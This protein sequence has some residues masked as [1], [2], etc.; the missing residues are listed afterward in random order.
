MSSG[1]T[2]SGFNDI[3]FNVVLNAMMTQAS[4]PLTALQDRQSALKS[5]LTSFETLR[6]R[7]DTLRSAADGLKTMDA[8]ST[9][10]GTSSNAA[11]VSISSGPS[12]TPAHYDVVVTSLARAQVTASAETFA[13]ADTTVVASG[14]SITIG[15]VAVALA[16]DTTLQGLA[17][18]INA[19]SDTGVTA[20]VVQTGPGAYRLALTSALTGTAHAFTVTNGLSGGAGI[21]FG[22]NVVDATDAA[23]TINN[24]AA[25]SSSNVFDNIVPGVTL[26]VQQANPSATIGLDVAT[27]NGAFAEK[28]EKFVAAYNDMVGF[29]EAQRVS[30]GTG[31]ERSIG[32]D[33]L[34]RQLRGNLR[35]ALLGA[36]GAGAYGHLAE[37][38][39]EFTRDGTLKLDR[40]KFDA[41]LSSN[42]DDA[43]AL[44]AGP[45]GAFPA[46]DTMLAEYTDTTGLLSSAR[47][48]I[49]KQITLMD[50]QI[51]AMQARLAIQR[52]ALQRQ[53]T[54]AD[55][56]MSRLKSQSGALSNLGI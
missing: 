15:G 10:A 6:T 4:V 56:V 23:I 14:G 36:H 16:G 1:I 13:D 21:S 33:P 40:A 5:R 29:L 26:T 50:G 34:L 30:A 38:G 42:P 46:V 11:A 52:D 24:I 51:L 35:S 47:D 39:V 48:R 18:A 3:D 55:A 41:A 45:D 53:F 27:D 44:F 2:F 12:A 22:A 31:D 49:N 43:R 17:D 25:T 9:T 20:A 54:E 37:V 32:G 8:V 28:I 19:A 7:I